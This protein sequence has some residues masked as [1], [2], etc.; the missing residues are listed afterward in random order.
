[1]REREKKGKFPAWVNFWIEEEKERFLGKDAVVHVG[2]VDMK[3]LWE[4]VWRCPAGSG[5]FV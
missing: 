1:M 4:R 2:N 3:Y 5:T